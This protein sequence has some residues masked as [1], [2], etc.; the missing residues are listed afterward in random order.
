MCHFTSTQAFEADVL[1]LL[2]QNLLIILSFLLES[3]SVK[4]SQAFHH[5][6]TYFESLQLPSNV[7]KVNTL[8]TPEM[9]LYFNSVVWGGCLTI[10]FV[11]SFHYFMFLAKLK[12][13]QQPAVSAGYWPLLTALHFHLAK[14][15]PLWA[16]MSMEPALISVF[17]SV[18]QM[19]VLTPPLMEH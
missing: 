8:K 12:I 7:G 19:R 10:I 17:C 5:P 11:I 15:N 9:D 16:K 6:S 4:M 1:Q 14:L 13:G 2:L 3:S 18:K